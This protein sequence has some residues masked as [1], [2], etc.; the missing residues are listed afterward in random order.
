M[1]LGLKQGCLGFRVGCGLAGMGMLEI[2]FGAG[3][4]AEDGWTVLGL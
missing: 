2:G 4:F 3:M 1:G